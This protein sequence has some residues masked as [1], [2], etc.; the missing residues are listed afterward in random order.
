MRLSQVGGILVVAG[1]VSFLLGFVGPGV[2]VVAGL[3]L[4]GFGA[5]IVAAIDRYP[6]CGPA[7]RLGLGGLGLGLLSGAAGGIIEA[8]ALGSGTDPLATPALFFTFVALMLTIIGLALTGVVLAMRAGPTRIPGGLLV[9]GLVSIAAAIG[10]GSGRDIL[11]P[12][13]LLI[14]ITGGA[15]VGG[16]AVAAP[17]DGSPSTD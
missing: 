16:L 10:T 5:L 9:A 15:W 1:S 12:A 2:F 8:L 7:V 11:V 6:L 3:L 13:G 17:E 14:V 4:C